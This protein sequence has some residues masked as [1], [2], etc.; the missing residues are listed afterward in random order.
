MSTYEKV[1]TTLENIFY[2][3]VYNGIEEIPGEGGPNCY[4]EL[5][6]DYRVQTAV[7]MVRSR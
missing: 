1:V 3:G 5:T 2:K 7:G 6:V 4:N